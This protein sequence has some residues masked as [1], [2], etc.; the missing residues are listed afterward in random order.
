[1]V[2][3]VVIGAVAALASTRLLGTLLF[4]VKPVDPLVFSAMSAMMIGMGVVASYMPAR[5]ASA[6]DPLEALRSD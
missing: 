1:V 3:G 5:R 4:G 6:V 2:V